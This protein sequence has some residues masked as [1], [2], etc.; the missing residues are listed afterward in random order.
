MIITSYK[1]L[2][3]LALIFAFTLIC[4]SGRTQDAYKPMEDVEGFRQKMSEASTGTKSISS[5]FIQM[6]FLSFLEEK[7]E[8]KGLFYF[9]KEDKLR[10]EYSEPFFYMIVFSGDSILI[11]D[12]ND[13]RVYDASSGRMFREINKIMIG[14]V[15]G[16]ILESNEFSFH[17]YENATSYRLE[18]TPHDENM[19]EFLYEIR[20]YI[21]KKDYSV[22]ELLM[23]E[24]S[25][26][27]THI[28]FV[29]KRL[30]EEIPQHIFDLH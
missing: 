10:W 2:G 21:N 11:R 26:D 13:S 20:L 3:Y 24:S 7:V 19:K 23:L 12:E 18:L 9:Q 15:N 22:D 16:T 14:M 6:K 4:L 17:Y 1:Y 25:D 5:D 27:Y 30:N 28:R 8:S 29:N